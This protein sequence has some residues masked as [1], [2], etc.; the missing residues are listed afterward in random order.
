MLRLLKRNLLG[1]NFGEI[2][3][4]YLRGIIFGERHGGC[5]SWKKGKDIFIIILYL[6]SGIFTYLSVSYKSILNPRRCLVL[7][8]GLVVLFFFDLEEG[9]MYIGIGMAVFLKSKNGR[10]NSLGVK[11]FFNIDSNAK[12]VVYTI[13]CGVYFEVNHA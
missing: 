1:L 11:L 4:G 12:G 8:L 9:E 6:C 13:P 5:L 3:F 7:S 2:M 10:R